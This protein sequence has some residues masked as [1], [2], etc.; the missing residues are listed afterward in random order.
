MNQPQQHPAISG[1]LPN[2]K[3]RLGP[4]A[5]MSGRKYVLHPS[6]VTHWRNFEQEARQQT[7]P[8]LV[9]QAPV[10]ALRREQF[11][12]AR[13]WGV[14]ARIVENIFQALGEVFSALGRDVR[15]ADGP[16]GKQVLF[17]SFRT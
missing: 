9:G 17:K 6:Q 12:V 4:K 3:L 5:R 14:Q 8:I 11:V 13:E 15:F 16:A 2:S 1:R 7:I 10:Q